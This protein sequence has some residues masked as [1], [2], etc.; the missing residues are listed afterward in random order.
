M[1]QSAVGS[2]Y[3]VLSLSRHTVGISN[4]LLSLAAYECGRGAQV[5]IEG[6]E[7]SCHS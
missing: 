4:R 1:G 3:S 5:S 2:A 6:R 7:S